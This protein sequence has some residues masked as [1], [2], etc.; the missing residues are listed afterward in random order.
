ML[1]SLGATISF[2]VLAAFP[3]RFHRPAHQ[4]PSTAASILIAST[5]H[6]SRILVLI[7]LI[8]HTLVDGGCTVAAVAV[9]RNTA[10][11]LLL[12]LLYL[13]DF[14]ED[15]LVA[16]QDAILEIRQAICKLLDEV[17]L[18]VKAISVI[19]ATNVRTFAIGVLDVVVAGRAVQ[20]ASASPLH[21]RATR[22]VPIIGTLTIHGV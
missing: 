4:F 21:M 13:P 2:K 14:V 3:H 9:V 7:L 5:A 12:L 8:M 10:L 15:A 16:V 20:A 6:G 22:I 1:L 19:I 17:E 18:I 11:G